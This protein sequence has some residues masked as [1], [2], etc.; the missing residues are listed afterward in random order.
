MGVIAIEF[1][2]SLSKE[3]V[4]A[5]QEKQKNDAFI[6]ISGDKKNLYKKIGFIANQILNL[7]SNL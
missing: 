5:R 7:T 6:W 1:G 4:Y 3:D 2:K